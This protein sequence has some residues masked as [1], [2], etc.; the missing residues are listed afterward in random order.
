MGGA[1]ERIVAIIRIAVLVDTIGRAM[2]VVVGS[3]VG[4]LAANAGVDVAIEVEILPP[5][6][7]SKLLW[8]TA[9]LVR[10]V[11]VGILQGVG[12]AKDDQG[13]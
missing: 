7:V 3:R 8:R 5:G 11:I 2:G 4:N 10:A 9:D 6:L 1:V 13:T 12:I